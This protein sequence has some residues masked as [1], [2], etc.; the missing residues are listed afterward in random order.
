MIAVEQGQE[1]TLRSGRALHTSETQV[2]PRSLKVSQVPQQLLDPKSSSLSDRRQ[3]CGL[4]V[5]EAES[6]KVSVLLGEGGQAGNDNGELGEE[7]VQTLSEEDEVGVAAVSR[8]YTD[9]Q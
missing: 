3:L 5:G 2:R 9:R 8:R 7:D 1:R 6:G 4:E